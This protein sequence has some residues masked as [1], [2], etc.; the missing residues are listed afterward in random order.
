MELEQFDEVGRCSSLKPV[1]AEPSVGKGIQQAERIVHA[2]RLIA[3]VI[4]VIIGFQ[5]CTS[6]FISQARSCSQRMNVFLKIRMDFLLADAA[7]FHV[8]VVHGDVHQVVQIAEHADLAELGHSRKQG[9]ADAPV[10]G[11]QSSVE[12]FQGTAVFVLQG[13]IADGL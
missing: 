5:L 11:F 4:T 9:K 1:T 2:Y 12:G 8:A 3:E 6:L 13:F 10:H 7:D